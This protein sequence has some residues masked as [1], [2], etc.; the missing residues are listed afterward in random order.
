[1]LLFGLSMAIIGLTVFIDGDVYIYTYIYICIFLYLCV[2][3][4]DDCCVVCVVLVCNSVGKHVC[5]IYMST[6]I[7]VIRHW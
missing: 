1:M 4:V 2:F 5:I 6:H 3:T 7:C